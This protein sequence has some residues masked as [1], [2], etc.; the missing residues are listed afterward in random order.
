MCTWILTSEKLET[1]AE[2]S[3]LVRGLYPVRWNNN[4]IFLAIFAVLR[5]QLFASKQKQG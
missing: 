2:Q 3:V 4:L 1:E 5:E